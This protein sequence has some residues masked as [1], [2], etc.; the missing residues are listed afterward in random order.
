MII[1]VEKTTEALAK[2]AAGEIATYINAHPDALLC[3]AAGD[4]PLRTMEA[5]IALQDEGKTNLSS[6]YYI[7]L[8][9]WRGIGY[10]TPG[11]CAQ[12]MEDHFY[13]PA[14]IPKE[15]IQVWDGKAAEVEAERQ[16]ME[17]WLAARGGIGLLL[18]GVGMNGHIGFNEPGSPEDAVTLRTDLDA[19]TLRVGPKYFGGAPCPTEGISIGLAA[20]MRAQKVLLMATGAHKASIMRRA[21]MEPPTPQVPASL[22]RKREQLDVYMDE[23][24]FES[25]GKTEEAHP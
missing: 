15:R 14:G 13:G 25:L 6:V 22:L 12:V 24:L 20:L 17:Q 8:D 23:A 11:S 5:L 19:T 9:E 10:E 1:T 7:G 2:T 4:T 3:L 21:L 16:R 18:L